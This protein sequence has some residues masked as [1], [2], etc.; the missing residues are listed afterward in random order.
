MK[1]GCPWA[2]SSKGRPQ[3]RDDTLV[4]LFDLGGFDAD[5]SREQ[6][7]G[8]RVQAVIGSHAIE[9][10]A[11]Y[12]YRIVEIFG[13]PGELEFEGQRVGQVVSVP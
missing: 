8:L 1:C 4:T 3:P 11:A 2:H 10:V 6:L 12:A 5:Q 13:E 9:R 7:D